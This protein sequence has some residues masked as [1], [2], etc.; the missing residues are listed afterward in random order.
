METFSIASCE[1]PAASTQ[2]ISGSY[3]AEYD[4]NA[5]QLPNE[6]S[7]A[8]GEICIVLHCNQILISRDSIRKFI[9]F[10][11]EKCGLLNKNKRLVQIPICVRVRVG[12]LSYKKC[13]SFTGYQN[14]INTGPISYKSQLKLVGFQ[15]TKTSD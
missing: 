3:L 14:Y 4:N 15:I 9:Y 11:L 6:D 8:R 5:G 2:S 1:R 12:L 10:T 7:N 13:I